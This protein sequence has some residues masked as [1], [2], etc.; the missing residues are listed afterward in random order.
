MEKSE[1]FL[2][3]SYLDTELHLH[4]VYFLEA[5]DVEVDHHLC[6]PVCNAQLEAAFRQVMLPSLSVALDTRTPLGLILYFQPSSKTRHI[7][8]FGYKCQ[9]HLSVEMIER[10][11]SQIWT[12]RQKFDL[13]FYLL[14]HKV[15]ESSLFDYHKLMARESCPVF[16]SLF[17]CSLKLSMN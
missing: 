6:G 8:S 16:S 5:S 13:I 7:Y 17:V 14:Q 15:G 2:P 11:C 9:I 1:Y 4:I 3:E 10:I 12:G